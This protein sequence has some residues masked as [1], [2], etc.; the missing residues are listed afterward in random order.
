[1]YLFTLF[2]IFII[3]NAVEIKPKLCINCKHYIP[4]NGK[5]EYGSCAMFTI[6]NPKSLVDGLVRDNQYYTCSTARS[7][8]NLCGKTATKYRKRYTKRI[9]KLEE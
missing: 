1:M 9:Q 6:E 2:C 4:N 5:P 3:A 7:W 8:T